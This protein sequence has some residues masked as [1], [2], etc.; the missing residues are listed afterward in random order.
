MPTDQRTGIP[1]TQTHW[2]LIVSAKAGDTRATA[3]LNELCTKYW[4]PLYAFARRSGKSPHEAEDLTKGFFA[5]LMRRPW[6]EG[7]S[8]EK[9]RFRTY[10]LRCLKN[11]TV[12]E[13]KKESCAKRLPP[14]G[15]GPLEFTDGETRFSKEPIDEETPDRL[16]QRRWAE[17]LVKQANVRLR[18][19]YTQ[20]GKNTL[21][22]HLEPHL[23]GR[24][25][26]GV[27]A[28]LARTRGKNEGALR[29]ELSRLRKAYGEV[30][31]RVVA[32]TVLDPG[33]VE[34][35]IRCLCGSFV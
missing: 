35:E 22:D 20:N 30:L 29:T 17:A 14:G 6:L 11:Y 5:H 24:V 2:T 8:Q 19:E 9:G 4:Y 7:I 32:E 13:W 26:H 12:N 3:A 15:V 33:E 21:F 25:E 27:F 16:F 1:F 23:G 28:D 31:R 10:L 34:T 18:A